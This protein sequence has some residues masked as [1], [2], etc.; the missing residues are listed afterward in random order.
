MTKLLGTRPDR[1]VMGDVWRMK[2]LR[3]GT[4]GRPWTLV[5]VCTVD[6]HVSLKRSIRFLPIETGFPSRT[7]LLTGGGKS[8]VRQSRL[9][10]RG[11]RRE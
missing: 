8:P 7:Y 10:D 1:T 2:R 3:H 11:S 9:Y 5:S 6:V 4:H